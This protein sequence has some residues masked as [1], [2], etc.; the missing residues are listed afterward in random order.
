MRYEITRFYGDEIASWQKDIAGLNS[1]A[2]EHLSRIGLILRMRPGRNQTSLLQDQMT[3]MLTYVN[4]F[5]ELKMRLFSQSQRLDRISTSKASID[6]DLINQQDKLR[7]KM[8]TLQSTFCRA[9]YR[10]STLIY[11]CLKT[12]GIS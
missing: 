5:D 8:Y 1:T 2:D 10:S 7:N 9:E 12:S 6:P 4:D 3:V 11:T